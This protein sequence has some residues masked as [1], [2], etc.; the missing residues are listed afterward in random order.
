MRER[1]YEVVFDV[2]L[3]QVIQPIDVWRERV[4]LIVAG[5]AARQDR[6][7]AQGRWKFQDVIIGHGEGA[8]TMEPLEIRQRLQ[9]VAASLDRFRV[10]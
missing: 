1:H 6:K 2:D 5:V 3:F 7:V 8:E 9:M 4:E 10:Y